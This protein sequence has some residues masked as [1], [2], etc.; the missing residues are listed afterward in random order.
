MGSIQYDF[1]CLFVCYK[2]MLLSEDCSIFMTIFMMVYFDNAV[3][4]KF[5]HFLTQPI[6]STD[7]TPP[8]FYVEVIVSFIVQTRNH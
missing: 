3:K 8:S 2:N 7:R 5:H 1:N 4:L 6:S